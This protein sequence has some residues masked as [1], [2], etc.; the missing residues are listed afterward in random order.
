MDQHIAPTETV[1]STQTEFLRQLPQEFEDL[2]EQWHIVRKR[3]CP[4]QEIKDLRTR[5]EQLVDQLRDKRVDRL[6]DRVQRLDER[7]HFHVRTQQPLSRMEVE[8]M[9]SIMMALRRAGIEEVPAELR[10]RTREPARMAG[11]S[12][13]AP[14]AAAPTTASPVV[15]ML[16]PAGAGTSTLAENLKDFGF[17]V[18]VFEDLDAVLRALP[19]QPPS[20]LIARL[21]PGQAIAD[22]GDVTRL[23][24]EKISVSVPVPVPVLWIVDRAD[25]Q[26]R[27]DIL[28]AGGDG[29]IQVPVPTAALAARLRKRIP[30]EDR[31]PHRVLL[32]HADPEV[33]RIH[34]AVLR[35][36]GLAVEG[37]DD[38]LQALPAA[39]RFAPE[40][41]LV[42]VSL[43]AMDGLEIAHLL[44]EEDALQAV[45]IVLLCDVSA[46]MENRHRFRQLG[47]DYLRHPFSESDLLERLS[48]RA[49]Q[50]RSTATR[51]A[52]RI[53]DPGAFLER[54]RFEA[55]LED[56]CRSPEPEAFRAV[57]FLEIAGYGQLS[58]SH[59]AAI[60]GALPAR[61]ESALR[62]SLQPEDVAARYDDAAY[63]LLI[64]RA[65]PEQLEA[66]HESV[67]QVAAEVPREDLR[68]SDVRVRLGMARVGPNDDVRA[69]LCAAAGRCRATAEADPAAQ[70]GGSEA[71]PVGSEAARTP[72][73]DAAGRRHW[74]SRIRD[75]ILGERLFLVFQPLFP[76]QGHDANERHEVLL[77]IRDDHGGVS[78]PSETLAMAEQLGMSVVL[79]RWV[80]DDALRMLSIHRRTSRNARFFLKVT[81]ATLQDGRFLEWLEE[82]LQRRALE[83]G[84][85]ALQIRET[86]AIAHRQRTQEM[87]RQLREQ[88]MAVGL[89]HF[90]LRTTS[91]E[92][93]KA[94]DVNFVKLAPALVQ[95]LAD[96]SNN[97][98]SILNLLHQAR[99][100]DIKIIAPCIENAHSLA[101]LWNEQ[102]DLLQGNFLQDPGPDLAYD[103]VL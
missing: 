15:F 58:Q 7:L 21:D 13:G 74:S 52:D 36:A 30:A 94:L 3:A 35:D 53:R 90:G 24:R 103:P 26:T 18:R 16:A 17:D 86:D 68:L 25:P 100:R 60:L 19:D 80:I 51:G 98:A 92:L 49:S 70:D 75:A 39:L 9:T 71:A 28:R 12:D 57:L 42:D 43:P 89:E 40:A 62:P 46:L 8:T 29:C 59:D 95:G 37:V 61:I 93:M 97:A 101:K 11:H 81:G 96:G 66:F 33:R 69:A 34:T 23:L 63:A 83:P 50:Y 78:L 102:I 4:L 38:P 67:R 2:V 91:F 88:G 22:L 20:A 73:L 31:P 44:R 6:L 65:G 27:L 48:L 64:Q 32:V 55:V 85:V 5:T 84:A 72:T 45:P 76:A 77:R 47:L 56:A 10:K 1:G 14:T 82:I 54:S 41:I 79:D 87:V 99:A